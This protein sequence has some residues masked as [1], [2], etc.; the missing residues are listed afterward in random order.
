MMP[1][2]ATTVDRLIEASRGYRFRGK[3]RLLDPFVPHDGEKLRKR[4][5]LRNEPRSRHV[6]CSATFISATTNAP[7]PDRFA[8]S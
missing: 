6:K 8:L 3:F 5:W 1:R 7:K 2:H 4:L